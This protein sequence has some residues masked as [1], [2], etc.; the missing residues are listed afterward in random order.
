MKDLVCSSRIL[1]L[2]LLCSVAAQAFDT[3]PHSDLTRAAMIE[4]GF[5]DDATGIVQVE[6]WLTDYYSSTP[7]LSKEKRAEFEK[8]HFDNLYDGREVGAYWQ[9][10]MASTRLAVRD[11]ASKGDELA[12]LTAVGMSLHAVQDFY[13]H[14]NWVEL[15]P[16]EASSYRTET[17]FREPNFSALFTGKYPSDRKIAPGGGEVPP[18]APNHG[19]YESGVNHDS[20][21]RP[22]WDEAYVF[23]YVASLEFLAMAEGWS[24]EAK[25]GFFEKARKMRLSDVDRR[26]LD[27]DLRAAQNLSMWIK[28][29]GEDGHW[30]GKGSGSARFF[31]TFTSKWVGKDSSR[32]VKIAQ[33]GAV[34]AA[35]AKDLYAAPISPVQQKPAKI[36]STGKRAVVVRL[37]EIAETKDTGRLEPDIDP[38][39]KPDFYAVITI[40]GQTFR[41]RILQDKSNAV[42]PWFAIAFVDESLREVPISVAV[43]DE[44]DWDADGKLKDDV[45]DINPLTGKKTMEVVFRVADAMLTGDVTGV[46]S[47]N[48]TF[49]A[50]GAKPDKNRASVRGYVYQVPLR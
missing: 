27:F 39:G 7:T 29:R 18:A 41:E 11:A 16:R 48:K 2:I 49:L 20:Q 44:D 42:D 19:D 26:K 31:D 38:A 45:V 46:F 37:T 10:L 13:S 1:V 24:D 43:F 40:G 35:L 6:N 21:I 30:K 33:E 25:P 34:A 17:Y 23:A 14:S 5:S 4:R 32:F 15:H 47:K 28:V 8:L 50:G 12:L 9:R 3:G 36:Y 22:R